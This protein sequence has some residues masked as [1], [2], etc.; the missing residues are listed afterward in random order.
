MKPKKSLGQNFLTSEGAVDSI[1]DAGDV[2]GEDII[3]E[4]G[5]G[6]GVLTKKLLEFGGKVLAVEKDDELFEVLKEKFK[7]ELK[8]KKLTLIHEDIL[9]F[10]PKDFGLAPNGYKLIANIPYNLT[11]QII[12]KFLESKIQPERMVLMVQREVA[13]RIVAKDGKESIL[14]I[15]VKAYGEPKYVQTVKAGSFFPIPN[16]DSAIL[17]IENISKNYFNTFS[18]EDFFRFVRAGFASKRKKLSSNLSVVTDKEKVK[19]AFEE[20][21]L[22]D[23]TRAEDIRT[24]I[25]AKIVHKLVV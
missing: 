25:W 17:L 21:K 7:K 11:G 8:N 13:Q 16:V 24:D 19:N 12:R 9:D 20:L 15:S 6:K 5:P 4:I 3:L 14:S 23:N 18:E 1:L 22:S 2:L 10:D